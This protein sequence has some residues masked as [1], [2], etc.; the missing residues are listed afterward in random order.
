MDVNHPA[1]CILCG[2]R[3]GSG[4]WSV[5]HE[6]VLVVQCPHFTS[7]L[8]FRRALMQLART[9]LCARSGRCRPAT[10][11][12]GCPRQQSEAALLK[13]AVPHGMTSGYWMARICM[14]CDPM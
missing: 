6:A 14:L 4:P 8:C 3:C 7:F 1:A 11:K 13:R 10:C 5:H 9:L 12:E 2:A